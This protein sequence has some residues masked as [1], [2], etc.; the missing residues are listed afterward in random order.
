ML[1]NTFA[2]PLRPPHFR[3][4]SRP[5][6]QTQAEKLSERLAFLPMHHGGPIK[7]PLYLKHP[8]TSQQ[9]IVLRG[10]REDFN[11]AAIMRRDVSLGQGM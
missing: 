4:S 8:L 2:L 6:Q 5:G 11:W 10:L 1:S 9:S 3:A 7:P